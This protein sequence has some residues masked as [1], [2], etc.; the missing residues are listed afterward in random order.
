MTTTSAKPRIFIDMISAVRLNGITKTHWW[1]NELIEHG[2][3]VVAATELPSTMG[4]EIKGHMY[5]TIYIDKYKPEQAPEIK[6]QKPYWRKNE[7]W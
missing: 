6:K 3:Q 4:T 2:Y 7:R 5:E 1:L